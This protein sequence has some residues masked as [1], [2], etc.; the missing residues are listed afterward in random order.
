MERNE[1]RRVGRQGVHARLRRAMGARRTIDDV[2]TRSIACAVPTHQRRGTETRGH[3]AQGRAFAHPTTTI[4]NSDRYIDKPLFDS[5]PV[6]G[7]YR[8]RRT[9][10][11]GRGAPKSD[12]NRGLSVLASE[13]TT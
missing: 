8:T 13:V 11:A 1:I 10:R 2:A 6:G 5:R 9:G 3:G 7:S 12:A 4:G